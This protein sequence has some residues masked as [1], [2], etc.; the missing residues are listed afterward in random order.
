M[1]APTRKQ[2]LPDR[3][4]DDPEQSWALPSWYYYDADIAAR[5]QEAIFADSWQYAGHAEQVAAPGQYLTRDIAGESILIIRGR[6]SALRAFYNVCSHRA[7]QLLQGAGELEQGAIVCP[8][9]AWTYAPEGQLLAA[10]N[11]ENVAGFDRASLCL[12]P[13]QVEVFVNLVFV[14]LNPD[15]PPLHGQLGGVED[16]L[17]SFAPELDFLTLTDSRR[18]EIKANWKNIMENYAECYHCPN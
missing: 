2:D 18:Y 11:S 13:A 14:N 10:R 17:R 15:A 9:H 5:E 12:K 1:P 6:D 7:H 16:E 4:H 3:F 8:Y